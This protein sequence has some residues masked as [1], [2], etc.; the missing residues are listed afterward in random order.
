MGKPN[1]TKQLDWSAIQQFYDSGKTTAETAVQ[2]GISNMTLTR[3]KEFKARSTSEA[4]SVSQKLNPRSLTQ[5]HKDHLRDVMLERRAN[6]YNWSFAHSKSNREAKSYPEEFFSTV[7]AN[8]F[9]DKAYLFNMP[10]HRFS[11]DFA[12]PEKKKV[13]EIDGEQHYTDKAQ[14]TRDRQK[15]LLLQQEG[16]TLLRIRWREFYR[17]PKPAILQANIFIGK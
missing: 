7:I 5:E 3:A 14:F 8:E 6:G 9:D 16:W 13:I 2:F 11:L 12:W 15:D 10:F 4:M 1:R 17:E